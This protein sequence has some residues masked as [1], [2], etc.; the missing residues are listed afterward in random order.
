M[1]WGG[2][3]ALADILVSEESESSKR[4]GISRAYYGAFNIARRWLESHGLSI[5]NR[6]AHDRVWRTFKS[7][8]H[9]M[10]DA[11]TKWQ[12][13]GELGAALR[14]LR[15]QADYADIVQGLDQEAVDAVVSAERII[16]L[17]DELEFTD[18]PKAAS[19]IT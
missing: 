1:I 3:V 19:R 15:N 7:A 8:E 6:R 2:Y 9:A 14:R 11:R 5:D 12:M 4:S 17:L 18:L 16:N 10:P 13:I